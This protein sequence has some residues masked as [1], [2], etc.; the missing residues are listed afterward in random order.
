M[1]P[2]AVATAVHRRFA[3]AADGRIWR[4]RMISQGRNYPPSQSPGSFNLSAVE[5]RLRASLGGN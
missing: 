1:T 2:V 4:T 3:T 5:E